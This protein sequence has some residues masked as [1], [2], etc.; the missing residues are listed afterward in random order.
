[1]YISLT[2]A[3]L[4][5]SL[6][7]DFG[8]TLLV[9]TEG[10][11]SAIM[12]ESDTSSPAL[13]PLT[14]TFYPPRQTTLTN[15]IAACIG[16]TD[17]PVIS[18]KGFA[19]QSVDRFDGQDC[20]RYIATNSC[21]NVDPSPNELFCNFS[22]YTRCNLYHSPEDPYQVTCEKGILRIMTPADETW[23]FAND[24][25]HMH[26]PSDETPVA[27]QPDGSLRFSPKSDGS[28]RAIVARPSDL[29]EY[30]DTCKDDIAIDLPDYLNACMGFSP[31]PI[32]E[33]A[34]E[35]V[36]ETAPEPE[37]QPQPQPASQPDPSS[38]CLRSDGYDT[39]EG[40]CAAQMLFDPITCYAAPYCDGSLGICL[41]A[42][43]ED[44]LDRYS[45]N[46][47]PYCR[48]NGGGDEDNETNIISPPMPQ[49]PSSTV[50]NGDSSATS[51]T[52]TNG[53]S[54]PTP[55]EPSSTASTNGND[56][57]SSPSIHAIFLTHA[58][59]AA[60]AVVIARGFLF[61]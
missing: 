32:P 12:S 50:T 46:G 35:P 49:Q 16:S 7:I 11:C 44:R 24:D 27:T 61:V 41:L 51:T 6:S 55:Q 57:S 47:L 21:C 38:G 31:A 23:V 17:L 10:Q 39:Y 33:P 37:S 42:R 19:L 3:L 26:F 15:F 22:R 36:A 58:A 9:D 25:G 30:A 5:F 52:A 40:A 8:E 45:C 18:E 48:W 54:L 34:P 43:C 2:V 1:M 28:T 60:V 13:T 29:M 53:D 4:T 59:N 14:Q 56:D 20:G